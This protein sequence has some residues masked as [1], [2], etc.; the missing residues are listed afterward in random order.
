MRTNIF[1]LLSNTNL[2]NIGRY[3]ATIAA[4]L[5]LAMPQEMWAITYKTKLSATAGTGGS[6]KLSNSSTEPNTYDGSRIEVNASGAG[7]TNTYYA[8]ALPSPGYVWKSWTANNSSKTG[9]L[10]TIETPKITI[11]TPKNGSVQAVICAAPTSNADANCDEKDGYNLGWLGDSRYATLIYSITANFEKITLTTRDVTFTPTNP[12]KNCSEY[13]G[14]LT[15][16]ASH[17]CAK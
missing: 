10:I 1:S 13:T 2:N 4:V 5:F 17:S 9:A 15:F 16:K 3:M 7:Q 14:T 12:S 6:V 8:W 11:E